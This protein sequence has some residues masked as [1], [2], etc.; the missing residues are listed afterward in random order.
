MT[1]PI[2][3]CVVGE[4]RGQAHDPHDWWYTSRG[5]G[6]QQREGWKPDHNGWDSMEGSAK[7]W[8]CPGIPI[9]TENWLG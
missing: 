4:L 3:I 6:H 2:H 1:L 9:T 8:H 7:E 5:G